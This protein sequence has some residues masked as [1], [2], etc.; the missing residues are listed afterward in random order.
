MTFHE[1]SFH[2]TFD[3]SNGTLGPVESYTAS[4]Q[5]L[6]KKFDFFLTFIFFLY[7]IL[8]TL[9]GK[10]IVLAKAFVTIVN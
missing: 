4:E 9:H 6:F 7:T 1:D 8:N 2:G 5:Y 10:N 3:R